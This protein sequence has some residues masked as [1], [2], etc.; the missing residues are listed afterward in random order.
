VKILAIQFRYLG[1]AVL[2]TPALRA[3]KEHFAGSSLHVLVAQEIAPVL[4]H[5]PW[6]ERV[7]AFPRTRGRATISHAW[8][9]LRALR[10]EQFDCSID[11]GGNDRG[12]IISLLC[13]ARQRVGPLRPGGFLGRRLCY[14]ENVPLAALPQPL[15]QAR[16]NFRL[17]ALWGIQMPALPVLEIRASPSLAARAADLLPGHP[18]LCHVATSQPKKEWPL[19]HWIQIHTQATAAGHELAFCAGTAP[20]EQALLAQIKSRIAHASILPPLP[21]LA[22]FLAVLNRARLFISGDTGP[23]HLAAGL[24][25]PTIGLFGPSSPAIW[26]PLGKGHHALQGSACTC[27]GHSAVCVSPRH[28]MAAITPDTVLSL[29]VQPRTIAV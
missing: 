25:V 4:Q 15:H 16:N 12:A 13:G 7:W 6:I 9:V 10:K 5:I 14:T 19:E 18:I 1:D 2:L 26:A 29:L 11:F 22:I 27:S 21:E 23:L 24:G 17:L 28:C 8:P 20:R 3:L